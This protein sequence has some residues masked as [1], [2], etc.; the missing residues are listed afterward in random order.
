MKKL[1]TKEGKLF[2]LINIIDLLVLLFILAAASVAVMFLTGKITVGEKADDFNG[3]VTDVDIVYYTEELSDFV[4][5]QIRYGAL[6]Y[7]DGCMH[8]LG[9]V[10]EFSF[11][12]SL[13]Y[14]PRDD[15]SLAV[16]EKD[17]YCS[18]FITGQANGTRTRL[19]FTFNKANY[20]VGHSMVLRAGDAKI[21]LRIYDIHATQRRL[22]RPLT[23]TSDEKYQ[24]MCK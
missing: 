14:G 12:K 21:Y 18:A 8:S 16:V 4:A 11:G 5:D 20:G 1:V 24:E 13:I 7:D 3:P 22:R 19:G 2:G 23:V 6:V 17:G 10:T 9:K 15:G